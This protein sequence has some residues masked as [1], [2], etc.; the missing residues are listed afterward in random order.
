MIVKDC[1]QKGVSQVSL[2]DCFGLQHLL[3]QTVIIYSSSLS[4]DI[5]LFLQAERLGQHP[6][7]GTGA[8][9]PSGQTKKTIV[10]IVKAQF[11]M[12]IRKHK[13]I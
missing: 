11:E 9:V 7:T 12:A 10:H 5:P 4:K 6:P 2:M 13:Y 1:Y 8:G 3:M